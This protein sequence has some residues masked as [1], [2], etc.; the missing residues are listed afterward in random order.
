MFKFLQILIPL[1]HKLREH[2]T[3]LWGNFD[4]PA[5]SCIVLGGGTIMTQC[6]LGCVLVLLIQFALFHQ[7]SATMNGQPHSTHK[8]TP[9]VFNNIMETIYAEVENKIPFGLNAVENNDGSENIIVCLQS[10]CIYVTPAISGPYGSIYSGSCRVP[11]GCALF[12]THFSHQIRQ[13]EQ[14][15]Y[16]FLSKSSSSFFSKSL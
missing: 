5:P 12:F 6:W 9:L 4:L 14:F 3:K 7:Y 2:I 15:F 8:R 10:T 1:D 11:A 16:L 13:M